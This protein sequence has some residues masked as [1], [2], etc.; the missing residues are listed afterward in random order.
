MDTY[1]ITTALVE[2]NGKYLIAKP[3]QILIGFGAFGF[4]L[5]IA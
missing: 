2:F 3:K 5:F 4:M 1:V